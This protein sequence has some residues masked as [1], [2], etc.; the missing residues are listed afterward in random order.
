MELKPKIR[1]D[2]V[3]TRDSV[4]SRYFF[5][6]DPP[7]GLFFRFNE[8]QVGMMEALDGERSIDDVVIHLGETF[9][10]EVEP[11]SVER[12]IERL[13]KDLLLDVASYRVDSE[14]DRI[15]IRRAL[16]KKGLFWR[17]ASKAH[18]GNELRKYSREF[19]AFQLGID[20]LENGDP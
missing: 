5:V 8:V 6:E 4:D 12:V 11:E 15:L 1:S 18:Q 2:L 17:G 10:I 20:E 9:E 19:S 13:R 3:Y 14:K 16:E 7:R